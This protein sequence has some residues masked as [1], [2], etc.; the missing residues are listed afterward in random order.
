MTGKE[1][2]AYFAAL[3]E[4]VRKWR[5]EERCDQTSICG[6]V[7]VVLEMDEK[8]L[9]TGEQV[10]KLIELAT[11]EETPQSGNSKGSGN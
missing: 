10:K 11:E 7:K 3:K 8:N 5:E 1:F 6:M 2:D 4:C 9:F